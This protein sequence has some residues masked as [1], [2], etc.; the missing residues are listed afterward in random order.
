MQFKKSRTT[1]YVGND[2]LD[3]RNTRS[4]GMKLLVN[5]P[6]TKPDMKLGI[7]IETGKSSTIVLEQSQTIRLTDPYTN[8]TN[9]PNYGSFSESQ[10]AAYTRAYCIDV[11]CQEKFLKK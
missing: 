10:E 4:I 5:E 6:G 11:C 9:K 3:L 8:C 7:G 2:N 1:L